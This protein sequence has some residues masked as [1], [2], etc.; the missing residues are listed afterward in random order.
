MISDYA[1]HRPMNMSTQ[2]YSL[3]NFSK[4]APT[5]PQCLYAVTRIGDAVHLQP[6]NYTFLLFTRL[7]HPLVFNNTR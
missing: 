5:I 1:S 4:H 7:S 3:Y 2:I 6:D